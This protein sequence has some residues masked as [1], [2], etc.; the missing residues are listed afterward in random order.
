[1]KAVWDFIKVSI[2]SSNLL[3]FLLVNFG[4][5]KMELNWE[6]LFD[7]WDGEVYWKNLG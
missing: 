6:N 3:N 2:L 1:M 5:R 4:R 7:D